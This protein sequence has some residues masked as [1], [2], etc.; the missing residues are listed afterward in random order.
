M[1]DSDVLTLLFRGNSAIQGRLKAEPRGSVG[2]AVAV[3]EELFAGRFADLRRARSDEDLSIAYGE[4]A[5]T[6]EKISPFP[7]APYP[8]RAIERWRL[9]RALRLNVGSM[10]LKIAAIALELDA[11]VV[12]RNVRDFRRVPGLRIEDWSA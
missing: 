1:L 8:V 9:L 3:V 7:V 4:L 12:T 6:A 10:D 2:I 11:A 5:L